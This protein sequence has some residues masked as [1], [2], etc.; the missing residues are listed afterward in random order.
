MGTDCQCRARIA[1]LEMENNALRTKLAAIQGTHDLSLLEPLTDSDSALAR[2]RTLA[3]E[4]RAL[5]RAFDG[6]S[7]DGITPTFYAHAYNEYD[8]LI[9]HLVDLFGDG[10]DD[11]SEGRWD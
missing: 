8:L 11:P 4:A 2:A 10:D 1:A 3:G 6:I 7:I 5:Q 9:R